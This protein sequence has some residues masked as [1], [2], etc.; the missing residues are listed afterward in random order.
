[1]KIYHYTI[2]IS[3]VLFSCKPSKTDYTIAFGS[4]NKQDLDQSYWKVISEKNPD[5]FIWGGDNIYA[6]TSNIDSL[7]AMYMTQKNN[8]HYK[9]FLK[10]IK[11]QVFATWDDHDYGLNDGGKEWAYKVESQ[12][13]FFDFLGVN[14][15]KRRTQKGIYST[16]VIKVGNNTIKLYILDTRYFRDSLTPATNSLKRYNPAANNTGTILG[17]K[18][19]SWLESELEQSQADFN[20]IMSS[21]Q[22]L[23]REHGFETWGN[24]PQE[25]DKLTNLLVKH[26]VNNTILLSGDR[27]ISE[28]S[29]LEVAGLD[30]PLYDFTSSGLTHVYSSFTSEPNKYRVGE[31]IHSKSFGLIKFNFKAQQLQ[32]EMISTTDGALQQ[33]QRV[34]F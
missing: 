25:F 8:I 15:P 10:S 6:D 16:E 28:F 5:A 29:K 34:Q 2:V 21:I 31:V 22:F 20:V 1:M 17:A 3:F 12:D 11:Y 4:C 26:K 13:A 30:Y 14:D 7:R 33:S 32:L 27:H 19:W 24:F 18:Q 9:N 23:S